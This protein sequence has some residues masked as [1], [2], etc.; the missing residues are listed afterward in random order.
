[1]RGAMPNEGRRM[2]DD[3]GRTHHQHGVTLDTYLTTGHFV[4]ATFENWK[5]EFLQMAAYNVLTVWFVHEGRDHGESP[6]STL[7][8]VRTSSFWFQ[9]FQN[10]QSEFLAVASIVGLTVVLRHRGSAESEPVYAPN[11]KTGSS[12]TGAAASFLG[13]DRRCCCTRA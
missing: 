4:E 7:E 6:V 13:D 1:M 11:S 2:L 10:W 3:D 5:S 9:S 8:F 12:R